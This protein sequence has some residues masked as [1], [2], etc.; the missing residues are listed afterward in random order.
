MWTFVN[1]SEVAPM[2]FVLISNHVAIPIIWRL[3]ET[4]WITFQGVAGARVGSCAGSATNIVEFALSTLST[5]MCRRMQR[6]K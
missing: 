5:E 6:P 4:Q 2:R 1:G 3:V